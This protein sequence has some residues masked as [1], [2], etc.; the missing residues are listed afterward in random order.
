M[1]SQKNHPH[2]SI[3]VFDLAALEFNGILTIH[4]FEIQSNIF[5][6][7]KE[8]KI[9]CGEIWDDKSLKGFMLNIHPFLNFFSC[10]SLLAKSDTINLKTHGLMIS[11]H[12]CN[13]EAR[14]PL[15]HESVGSLTI[16]CITKFVNHLSRGF[17]HSSSMVLSSL[18]FLT[19]EIHLTPSLVTAKE[20]VDIHILDP[21][22][23]RILQFSHN[24]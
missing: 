4:L 6:R 14:P 15:N 8:C 16:P 7:I 17:L 19:K 13:A 2:H 1:G 22:V 5:K 12:V 18:G 11:W 3:P 9:G 10:I 20:D 24:L 23:T 21:M